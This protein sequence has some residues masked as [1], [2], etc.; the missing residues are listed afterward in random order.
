MLRAIVCALWLTRTRVL[1]ANRLVLLEFGE[2][3]HEI[4]NGDEIIFDED[5]MTIVAEVDVDDV[6]R[7]VFFNRKEKIGRDS[8]EPYSLFG[9]DEDGNYL[10]GTLPE[11]DARMRAVSVVPGPN[12]DVIRKFTVKYPPQKRYNRMFFVDPSTNRDLQIIARGDKL[13]VSFE[14]DVNVRVE[15]VPDADYVEFKLNRVSLRNESVAP[16]AL[17]GDNDGDYLGEVLAPGSY[18]I[19]ALLW[20]ENARRPTRRLIREFQVVAPGDAPN[21]C[22]G[23]TFDEVD[24]LVVI[25][26]E[27]FPYQCSKGWSFVVTA[28]RRSFALG[29]G[30]LTFTG[31]NSFGNPDPDSQMTVKVNIN[32]A[33]TY[34]V[35]WRSFLFGEEATEF[36]DSWLKIHGGNALFYGAKNNTDTEWIF[37][38]GT[39]DAAPMKG[40]PFPEGASGDGF[41]KIYRNHPVYQWSWTSMTS[42]FDAHE[43]FVLFDAPGTYSITIAGRSRLHSI[44]RLVMHKI[45]PETRPEAEAKGWGLDETRALN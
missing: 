28:P 4:S 8:E 37:P 2:E 35:F 16:Y 45:D 23:V 9:E 15:F 32:Q 10:T 39:D 44:D 40:P 11:G 24:G 21:P 38:R 27:S 18:R 31:K 36:N 13:P 6:E 42:D 14:G 33:G 20:R 29:R 19:E 7:V 43:V 26:A 22:D 30:Y 17:F 5:T 1:A 34:K 12:P 41:L 3:L 25:E